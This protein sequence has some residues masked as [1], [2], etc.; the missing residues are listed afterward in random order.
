MDGPRSWGA[1]DSVAQSPDEVRKP[2]LTL[3]QPHG[4][5]ALQTLKSSRGLPNHLAS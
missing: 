3:A 1:G 4:R 5:K 2:V